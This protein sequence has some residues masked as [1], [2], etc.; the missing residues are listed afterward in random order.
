MIKWEI[1]IKHFEY[2]ELS[3]NIRK[4]ILGEE[5]PDTASS[6]YNIGSIFIK[7]RNYN[8]ALEYNEL[9][10]KIRKTNIRRR[11][12]MYGIIIL[13]YWENLL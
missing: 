9:S 2:H 13:L 1:I 4:N 10:L 3:L 11:A 12:P 8:K 7:M 6:Y 5:H